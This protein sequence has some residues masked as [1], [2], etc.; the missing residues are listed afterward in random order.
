MKEDDQAEK[1]TNSFDI[2]AVSIMNTAKNAE[3]IVTPQDFTILQQDNVRHSVGE[4]AEL[5]NATARKPSDLVSFRASRLAL[6]ETIVEFSTTASFKNEEAMQQSV[7]EIYGNMKMDG[8]LDDIDQR[9]NTEA[10]DF[11][12]TT[13]ESIEGKENDLRDLSA[14]I[15]NKHTLSAEQ[16]Q[17]WDVSSPELQKALTDVASDYK[18][19]D[20]KT[21]MTYID[22]I[23]DYAADQRYSTLAASEVRE[24]VK[25][26]VS[27][28][29]STHHIKPLTSHPLEERHSVMVAGGQSSGKGSSVAYFQYKAEQEG[30]DW[31]DQV[32]INSDSYK[33]LL[34]NQN[35]PQGGTYYSQLTQ[36]EAG[37]IHGKIQDRVKEKILEGRAPNVFADQVFAGEDK[38][39]LAAG[40]KLDITVVSLPIEKALDRSFS[41]GEG[42][43]RFEHAEGMLKLH[44]ASTEQLVNVVRKNSGN[45]AITLAVVD[46][47]VSFG[48][49][50]TVVTT[51]DLKN[52]VMTIHDEEKWKSFLKKTDINISATSND[53]LYHGSSNTINDAVAAFHNIEGLQVVTAERRNTPSRQELS[54]T[55]GFPEGRWT[56]EQR[57]KGKEISE[58]SIA[59]AQKSTITALSPASANIRTGPEKT[60][61]NQQK[62][63]GREL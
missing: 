43:G 10:L 3:H 21:D 48:E 55:L 11:R 39:N 35:S 42:T 45:S 15:Q 41:R 31:N 38:I 27:N 57:V 49:Q 32:K 36:D 29:V 24:T 58:S 37:A 53:D 54:E 18:P 25:D 8:R 52:K 51:F 7:R 46:N 4:V 34:V 30:R 14:A 60:V 61:S 47:D 17:L 13:Y 22:L 62:Q 19:G 63:E 5:H 56:E 59:I 26:E 9:L 23:S 12:Q 44:K 2:R 50:P 1:P 20:H 6:H 33:S 16:Q 28:Y 40:G